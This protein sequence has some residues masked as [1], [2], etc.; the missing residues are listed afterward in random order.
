M[1]ICVYAIAKNE[2]KFVERFMSS[3]KEADLIIVADTGSTDGTVSKLRDLGA[4]VHEIKVDPWRFD[5]ARNL[6]LDLIPADVEV[7]VSVDLDEVFS[8]GWRSAIEEV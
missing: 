4:I 1:K 8:P 5:V 3:M 2:E 7:C 6:A